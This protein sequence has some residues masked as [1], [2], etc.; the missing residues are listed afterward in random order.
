MLSARE[1]MNVSKIIPVISVKDANEM[2]HLAEALMQGGLSIFEITLRTPKALEAIEAVAKRFPHAITGAG[3]VIN[4]QTY[5]AV[6]DAGAKFAISPGLTSSLAKASQEGSIA[7]LPG[8]ATASEIM[9]GLEYGFDAFKLFPATAVGGI[10][11][12]KAFGGPFQDV[13]FCPTGG[14]NVN[15]AQSFLALDNVLCIGGS[16]IVPPSLIEAGRF[17][18]I[19]RLT[20]EALK[21]LS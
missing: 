5:Q 6:Q 16:W 21:L 14:I 18:E 2:L 15:N 4:A 19:T 12:L 20:K 1:I 17:D 10:E 8:V 9:S 3:T 13:V 11:I 7:L